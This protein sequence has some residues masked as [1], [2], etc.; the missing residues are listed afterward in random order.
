MNLL[1]LSVSFSCQCRARK[2]GNV[3][4]QFQFYLTLTTDTAIAS[5]FFIDSSYAPDWVHPLIDGEYIAK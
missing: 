1:F 4:D 2:E 3:S 5:Y